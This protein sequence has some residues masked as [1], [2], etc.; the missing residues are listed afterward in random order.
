MPSGPSVTTWVTPIEWFAASR[1]ELLALG[2]LTRQLGDPL[3]AEI[4]HALAVVGSLAR[5]VGS[6]ARLLVRSLRSLTGSVVCQN[7]ALTRSDDRP[8]AG[9]AVEEWL[10]AAWTADATIGLLS[11]HR[12]LGPLAWYWACLATEGQPLLHVAEWDVPVRSDPLL[13]KAH[14]LWAEHICDAPMEQW[15]IGNET[16]AAALDDPS[17]AL[18][19]AYGDPDPD[20]V[21]R[22]VVRDRRGRTDRQR[23]RAARRRA[24]RDRRRRS[25][26]ARTG[27][28]RGRTGGTDGHPTLPASGRSCC[29]RWSPT[30]TCGRRSPSPMAA[31]PTSSLTPDGWRERDPRRR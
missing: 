8:H 11:G 4:P 15:T 16:Y 6:L 17:D 9:V 19:R 31:R 20:R 18:G 26:P 21:R 25:E 3:Q 27:R 1:R 14:A 10:F 7:M 30:P 22:R 23:L 5:A 28:G 12:L 24:R 29:R 13:V 2:D